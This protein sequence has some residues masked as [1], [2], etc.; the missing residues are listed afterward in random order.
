MK[1]SPLVLS[2]EHV[3][4]GILLDLEFSQKTFLNFSMFFA[5]G[6]LNVKSWLILV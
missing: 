4:P 6:M 5:M 3:F 2:L 1:D